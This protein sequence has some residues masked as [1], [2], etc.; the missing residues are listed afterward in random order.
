VA[1]KEVANE[2]CNQK[3]TDIEGFVAKGLNQHPMFEYCN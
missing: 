3:P 1:N 2:I